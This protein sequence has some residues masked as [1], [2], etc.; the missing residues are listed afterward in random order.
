MIAFEA[1][2]ALLGL[3]IFESL[4]QLG[5]EALNMFP[6]SLMFILPLITLRLQ[7][8]TIVLNKL[9]ALIQLI[10]Q[11]L[12]LATESA[13]FAR[14]QGPVRLGIIIASASTRG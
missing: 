1:N 2:E 4:N 11:L 3:T 5:L 10:D 7:V 6:R 12:S 13:R 8:E 14:E 9:D